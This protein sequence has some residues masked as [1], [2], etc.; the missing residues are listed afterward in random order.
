MRLFSRLISTL[1]LTATLVASPALA[2][3]LG[4]TTTLK[5]TITDWPRGQTAELRLESERMTFGSG[6]IDANG[7][8]TLKLPGATTRDLKLVPVR[9]LLQSPDGKACAGD[10][11]VTP[12]V[13]T[14]RFFELV[15]YRDGTFLGDVLQRSSARHELSRGE[16]TTKLVYLDRDAALNGSLRCESFTDEW[17]S[18]VKAGWNLILS[19]AGRDAKGNVTF[20]RTSG[21]I[22]ATQKWLLYSEFGGVG[23][24]FIPRL[25]GPGV[26]I[27]RVVEGMP[28]A[29]AGVHAGDEIVSIDGE[30]AGAF[31]TGDVALRVM[32]DPGTHLTLVVR[33]AGSATPLSFDLVRAVVRMP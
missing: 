2:V 16:V 23:L 26:R 17:N 18:T 12:D 25:D 31:T 5:G 20:Q 33:R 3:S 27:E 22:L 14:F 8:F 9:N 10:A 13:G 11:R 28:A 24:N 4:Q 15:A 1:A 19:R 30:D 32:G 29:R 6:T 21:P 7:N